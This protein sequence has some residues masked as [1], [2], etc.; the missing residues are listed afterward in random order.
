MNIATYMYRALSDSTHTNIKFTITSGTRELRN[1]NDL[2]PETAR[3][4]YGT[5]SIATI[6]PKIFNK[7]PEDI[8]RNHHQHAYK[9][10]LKCHLRN[11]RFIKSC[12]DASFFNFEI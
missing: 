9:W 5:K 6:G 3:T 12:F 2:R 11:E 4:N 7:L 1:N 10:T 8:K